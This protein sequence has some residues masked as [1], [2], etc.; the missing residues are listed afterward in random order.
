MTQ[1][2]SV[3]YPQSFRVRPRHR[4]TAHSAPKDEAVPS[5]TPLTTGTPAPLG[6]VATK[7]VRFPWT[8]I[9]CDHHRSKHLISRGKLDSRV[10][11]HRFTVFFLSIFFSAKFPPLT[12]LSWGGNGKHQKA[13]E[14]SKL[15]LLLGGGGNQSAKGRWGRV[16]NGAALENSASWGQGLAL[17]TPANRISHGASSRDPIHPASHSWV[18][19]RSV[20]FHRAADLLDISGFCLIT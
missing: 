7:G 17:H 13:L 5:S 16:I 8:E 14:D 9:D 12:S 3:L 18:P 19:A 15:D 20:C 6:G 1:T 11:V 2:P 4:V 10:S